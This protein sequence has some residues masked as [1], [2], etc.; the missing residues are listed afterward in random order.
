MSTLYG[1]L[2]YWKVLEFQ[3]SEWYRRSFF[4]NFSFSLYRLL[5]D[6]SRLEAKVERLEGQLQ[7]KDRE[8]ATIT[9]TVRNLQSCK[10]DFI[11]VSYFY[12]LFWNLSMIR[13]LKLQQ[14]LSP[15]LT[16][17]SRSAMSFRG[18]SSA[19]R[20]GHLNLMQFLC[21]ILVATTWK[22]TNPDKY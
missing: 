18:W 7:A 15:K 20:L 9:R 16:N 19:I 6:I 1:L 10:S 17:Y 11:L 21:W 4:F 14:L 3:Y 22:W 2:V 8:I 12:W 13:K 5:S